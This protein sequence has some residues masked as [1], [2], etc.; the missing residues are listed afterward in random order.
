MIFCYLIYL[1]LRLPL[2]LVDL[3]TH[4]FVLLD[5][6]VNNLLDDL[7]ISSSESHHSLHYLLNF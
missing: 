6:V 7:S 2:K 4:L 3:M 5:V 1:Q